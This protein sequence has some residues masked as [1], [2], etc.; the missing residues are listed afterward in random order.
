MTE[1]ELHENLS[2]LDGYQVHVFDNRPLSITIYGEIIVNGKAAVLSFPHVPEA[3]LLHEA[4]GE[5]DQQFGAS[6]RTQHLTDA[7]F[8][9]FNTGG[10]EDEFVELLRRIKP[11]LIGPLRLPDGFYLLETY[12]N[13][14]NAYEHVFVSDTQDDAAVV[15]VEGTA[16]FWDLVTWDDIR[17][18]LSDNGRIESQTSFE[19]FI[20][21]RAKDQADLRQLPHRQDPGVPEHAG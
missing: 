19:R 1:T 9:F 7:V 3:Q 16:G 6:S 10:S 4:R 18:R 8:R 12:L 17:E 13:T 21:K 20:A 11:L 5:N 2:S 14:D 15:W